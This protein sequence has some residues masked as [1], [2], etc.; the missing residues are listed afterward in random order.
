MEPIKSG[1]R[2]ASIPLATSA[3]T[4]PG[5]YLAMQSDKELSILHAPEHQLRA[6]LKLLLSG[7]DTKLHNKVVELYS[8]VVQLDRSSTSNEKDRKR[9]ANFED[10][11]EKVTKRAH[12]VKD[13][14][15]CEQC[16]DTF[17]ESENSGDACQYHPGRCSCCTHFL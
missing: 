17:L 4:L 9:K 15:I 16:D 7:D 2:D 5:K 6:L 14:H 1:E 10:S 3:K 11:A 8:V 13:I 12:L